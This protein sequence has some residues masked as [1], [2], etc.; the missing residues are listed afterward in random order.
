MQ[1]RTQRK[2]ELHML[3]SSGRVKIMQRKTELYMFSGR[4]RTQRKTALHMLNSSEN[5]H[6]KSNFCSR[7]N[8]NFLMPPLDPP[9]QDAHFGL[10][11]FGYIGGVFEK[12][13]VN[14]P[15]PKYLDYICGVQKYL[16]YMIC[17]FPLRNSQ[18]KFTNH[19]SQIFL[20]SANVIQI[21]W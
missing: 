17:E 1:S 18:R 11:R 2:T 4:V 8:Y 6:S 21:F 20:N 5:V 19:V 12:F 3:N 16:R 10:Y 15:L 13:R 7:K 9:R 14:F